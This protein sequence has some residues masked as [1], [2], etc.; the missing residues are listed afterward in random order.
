M[1]RVLCFRFRSLGIGWL[2]EA[3]DEFLVFFNDLGVGSCI[4]LPL[5]TD[6]GG[7]WFEISFLSRKI[8]RFFISKNNYKH[9]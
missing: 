2:G 5:S 1:D 7:R 9:E 6:Q 8:K 4:D 3:S